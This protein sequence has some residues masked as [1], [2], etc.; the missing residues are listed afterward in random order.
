MGQVEADSVPYYRLPSIHFSPSHVPN[1]MRAHR[2]GAHL[3]TRRNNCHFGNRPKSLFASR[4]DVKFMSKRD[5]MSVCVD[6]WVD[7]RPEIKAQGSEFY[8]ATR[9]W[10]GVSNTSTPG[11]LH[12]EQNANEV[13]VQ[14]L[15][16]SIE[17]ADGTSHRLGLRSYRSIN[18]HRLSQ[19]SV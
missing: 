4:V 5:E 8:F 17:G 3:F 11:Y 1:S 7:F 10:I 6:R 12:E 13:V 9:I 2:Y 18:T 15:K 19:A 16:A 14:S